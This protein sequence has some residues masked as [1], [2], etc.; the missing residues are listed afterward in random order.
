MSFA[1]QLTLHNRADAAQVYDKVSSESS[2]NSIKTVRRNAARALDVPHGISIAHETTKDGKTR[3]SA[4][5]FDITEVNSVD[6]VTHS[7]A[8]L[9]IK[10]TYPTDGIITSDHLLDLLNQG[11][12]FLAGNNTFTFTETNVDKV[13]N[14]ES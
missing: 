5:M 10:L 12:E 7:S 2:K 9:L 14:L 3:R 11:I 1:D 4:I 6:L 13:L 8:Q